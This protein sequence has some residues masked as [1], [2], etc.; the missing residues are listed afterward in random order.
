MLQP[1]FSD[2]LLS[3]WGPCLAEEEWDRTRCRDR[4][5]W[6]LSLAAASTFNQAPRCHSPNA[7]SKWQMS[8]A[9]C[10][11]SR[12]ELI[13]GEEQTPSKACSPSL[14]R[15]RSRGRTGSIWSRQTEAAESVVLGRGTKGGFDRYN[16]LRGYH[17]R[18]FNTE[19]SA[20]SPQPGGC[21]CAKQPVLNQE[22]AGVQ[23][24]QSSTRKVWACKAA[25]QLSA[26]CTGTLALK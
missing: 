14:F 16:S 15:L 1:F 9:A 12:E 22:G 23:S 25:S 6:H 26:L 4:A 11:A 3:K 7:K 17:G 18:H 20:S 2:I 8:A 24:S 13:C 21:R 10:A 19:L 5:D